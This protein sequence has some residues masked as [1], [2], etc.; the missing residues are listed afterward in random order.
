MS[1]PQKWKYKV[2]QE[3]KKVFIL[4]KVL[5]EISQEVEASSPEVGKGYLPGKR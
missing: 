4:Y 2:P 3:W 1:V 5:N